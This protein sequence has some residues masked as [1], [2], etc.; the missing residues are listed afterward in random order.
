MT[1]RRVLFC[2]ALSIAGILPAWADPATVPQAYEKPLIQFQDG[3][4]GR[5]SYL[6]TAKTKYETPY[7]KIGELQEGWLCGHS[8]DIVW[9]EKVYQLFNKKLPQSFRSQLESAHYPVPVAPDAIFAEP[10]NKP[11]AKPELHVG[12]LIKDVAANLC[13]KSDSVLGGAYMKVFWQVYAPEAQK[14]VFETTTEGSYQTVAEEMGSAGSI[15]LKAYEMAARNLLASQ[16]F[17]DAVVNTP[18]T[19]PRP[20]EPNSKVTE[21]SPKAG[22]APEI[23]KLKRMTLSDEPLAK[24]VTNLR[25]AVVTILTDTG[26]GSGF[27]VSADGYVLTN[28]HVVGNANIVKVKLATGRELV[29]EVLRSDKARDVALVKTEPTA[30]K[31][32]GVRESEP[33]I[34]EEVYAL[35][36]PLGEQ[37]STTLTRGILSGYRTLGAKRFLQSDVSI[38]PGNS[39]GPLLDAKGAVIGITVSR[40]P[41]AK[42]M[43]G[44][45]FF[46]PIDD[47][48]AKLGLELY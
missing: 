16:G 19:E 42:V 43:A 44:I 30:V 41:N 12:M 40:L 3:R 29:G 31:A 1:L 5:I 4:P 38:L 2:Q 6:R 17:Y 36:S 13:L 7:A 22:A 32:M 9:N 24:N 10:K 39:G 46:I 48:L 25:S 45:S 21:P 18:I 47:A 34:G 28:Q 8:G 27:F 15:F 35:G 23:L 37:F 20:A 14:V 26:S 11:Q 33:N